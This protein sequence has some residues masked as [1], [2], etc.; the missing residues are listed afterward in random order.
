M[1]P[2]SGEVTLFKAFQIHLGDKVC[3]I[4]V[5]VDSDHQEQSAHRVQDPCGI[6]RRQSAVFGFLIV[7]IRLFFWESIIVKRHGIDAV[8]HHGV[9]IRQNNASGIAEFFGISERKA[10]F[11]PGLFSALGKRRRTE[12][13]SDQNN[14]QNG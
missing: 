2:D 3:G 8:L 1:L 4:A 7:D 5:S 6:F 13:E 11:V 12:R 14:E 10:H 9:R